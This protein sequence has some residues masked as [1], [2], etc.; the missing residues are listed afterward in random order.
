ME[1]TEKWSETAW[2]AAE[3]IYKAILELPFIKQLTDG[4]LDSGIFERY[5]RQDSLYINVYS[6]VL[7]DIASRLPDT[8]MTE[9][10]LGFAL[11]GTAAER[12]LHS[13]FIEAQATGMSPACRFY[14][15]VL[16]AQ[17]LSPVE[18]EAAAVLPCFW[19]YLKV[20]LE[21]AAKADESNPYHEWIAMYSQPE[22]A[23]STERAIAICDALAERGTDEIRKRMTEIFVECTRLEW[24]FWHSAYIDL[25]W[26]I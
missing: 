23:K 16:Q 13:Q 11:E 25:K 3:P 20:G 1:K 7:A 2:K 6:K 10:F 5:I 12:S 8:E 24:L 15:T 19:V 4:T 17:S 18:V 21:I 14:T 22:F 26:E 9:A